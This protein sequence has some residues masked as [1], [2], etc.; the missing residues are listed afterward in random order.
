MKQ[1][2]ITVIIPI[3]NVEQYIEKC[4]DS[5][6]NQ[7]YPNVELLLINDG[8]TDNTRS[9]IEKYRLQPNC[10]IIDKENS[11]QCDCRYIG[12][13]E[14]KGEFLYF[15]DSDDTLV[16]DGLQKLYDSIEKHQADFTCCR[17][18]IEDE[19]GKVLK[20][21]ADFEHE[22]ISGNSKIYHTR[23]IKDAL[24]VKLF[25]KSFLS[26]Y[27]ITP[28]RR[29]KLHDDCMFTELCLLKAEKV[30]FVNEVLYH[31]LERKNSVSRTVKPLMITITDQMYGIIKEELCK[32]GKFDEYQDK[33]YKVYA[34]SLMYSFIL[35]AYKCRDYKKYKELYNLVPSESLYYQNEYYTKIWQYSKKYYILSKLSRYPWLMYHLIILAS[36]LFKH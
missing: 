4:V 3:Y 21:D 16:P 34:K 6:L 19:D 35:A 20:V 26:K 29:I 15:M 2:L 11:G 10:R 13:K 27:G 9:I 30:S 31:V 24:W 12:L 32:N 8:S 23:Q 33:F 1:H 7:T 25:R 17:Y 14:S 36:P 18:W 22:V 28:D 5:I